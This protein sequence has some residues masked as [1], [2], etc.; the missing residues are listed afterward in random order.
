MRLE[1]ARFTKVF[2][3]FFWGTNES[4][5]GIR[6]QVILRPIFRI[7]KSEVLQ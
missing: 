6:S 7:S 4:V 1:N 5:F 2:L 3:M